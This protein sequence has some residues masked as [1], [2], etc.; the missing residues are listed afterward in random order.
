[1]PVND[2]KITFTQEKD[3]DVKR[4]VLDPSKA[5]IFSLDLTV[6]GITVTAMIFTPEKNC[7]QIALAAI[8]KDGLPLDLGFIEHPNELHPKTITQFIGC[9]YPDIEQGDAIA[10]VHHN[11]IDKDRHDTWLKAVENSSLYP[12][13]CVY[14]DID[15]AKAVLSDG[16]TKLSE[17]TEHV[18]DFRFDKTE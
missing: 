18:E 11:V 15:C 8:D 3:H 2:I 1:M 5:D 12:R 16:K 17:E 7:P 9:G 10:R 13:K 14:V 6:N 4:M